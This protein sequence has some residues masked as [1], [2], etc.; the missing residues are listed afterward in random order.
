MMPPPDADRHFFNPNE[1]VEIQYGSLPHW[2]QSGVVCFLTWRTWDSIPAS[3][4]DVWAADRAAW[5]RKHG[6]DADD[7]TWHHQLAKLPREIRTEFNREFSGRFEAQLDK[8]QGECA[9]R[10]PE[11]SEIVARSLRHFDGERY[12]LYDFVVMPNHVHLLATFHTLGEMMDQCTN[13]KRFTSTAINRVL[14]RTGRFWQTECFDHLV[15]SEVRFLYYR[16]YI[17]SNPDQAGL[18][19][20]EYAHYSRTLAE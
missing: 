18:S 16:S 7:G 20:G 5:L 15:R 10:R 8:C 11:L 4:I 19:A 6:L 3:W 13:W 12:T 1:D 17:A 2:M 14:G 9:L